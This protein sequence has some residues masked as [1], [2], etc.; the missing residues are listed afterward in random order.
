MGIPV[1]A[2][3]DTSYEEDSFA[4]VSRE[5]GFL[6]DEGMSPMNAIRAATS[7]AARMYGI[8][9]KTGSIRPGLE[10]DLIL[11]DQDPTQDIRSIQDILLVISNGQVAYERLGRIDGRPTTPG[12][13]SR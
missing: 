13:V 11:V 5:I 1:V 10:A 7:N 8:E 6:V 3:V 4:R 12:P 9:D 2:G